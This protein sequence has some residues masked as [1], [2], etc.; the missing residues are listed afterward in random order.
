M[1]EKAFVDLM[2]YNSETDTVEAT[3]ALLNGES[4]IIKMIAENI[5]DFVGNWDAVWENIEL[6][7]RLRDTLVK[8]SEELDN[9]EMLE[10]E[11]VIKCNDKFHKISQQVKE[12]K[13]VLDHKEIEFRWN[14]WFDR[15]IKK[16]AQNKKDGKET[17]EGTEDNE[18]IFGKQEVD[19]SSFDDDKK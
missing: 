4:D 19:L 1:A 18:M 3:D 9:D 17:D 8:K 6:R 16:I 11:F 14:D 10:A 5:P 15:E 2:K 13:S 12:S 7:G